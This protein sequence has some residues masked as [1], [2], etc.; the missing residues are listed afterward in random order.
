MISKF[1]VN[2]SIALLFQL[3]WYLRYCCI[4]EVIRVRQLERQIEKDRE[5]LETELGSLRA[6]H[7]DE[8]EQVVAKLRATESDNNILMASYSCIFILIHSII[9]FVKIFS[10]N[11]PISWMEIYASFSATKTWKFILFLYLLFLVLG[12]SLVAIRKFLWRF[13]LP[14]ILSNQPCLELAHFHQ[15]CT[16]SLQNFSSFGANQI[17]VSH[18]ANWNLNILFVANSFW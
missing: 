10:V 3:R 1:N 16:K 8:M 11:G 12:G 2:Q 15:S 4:L 17:K 14:M 9:P 5:K 18:F 6:Q 7:Q 13:C